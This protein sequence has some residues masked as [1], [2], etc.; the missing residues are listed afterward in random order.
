MRRFED[1]PLTYSEVGATLSPPLPSGYHV[2]RIERVIGAGADAFG[3]AAD[4]LVQWDA[5][6]GAGLSV[7][8]SHARAVV[9]AVVVLR[10]GPGRAGFLAP[11]RVVAVVDEPARHG[12]AYGTLRGHPERGEEAFI[13]ELDQESGQ[14][15]ARIVAFSAAGRWYTR[16][17]WFLPRLVQ[18][19]VARRYLAALEAAAR[20][21]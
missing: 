8:S 4:A 7:W 2:I 12:F 20:G 9:G 17:G 18:R 15:T 6:R 10:V 21:E 14:V 1:L 13:V 11:C 5:H 16:L 3:R 19:A